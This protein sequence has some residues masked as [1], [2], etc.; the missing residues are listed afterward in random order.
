[1]GEEE[2]EEEEEKESE[3]AAAPNPEPTPMPSPG[4]TAQCVATLESYYKDAKVWEPYCKNVGGLGTCPAPMCRMTTS[5]LATTKKHNFLGNA[6]LQTITDVDH[7]TYQAA[8]E[9]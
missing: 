1:M 8:E 3:T 9:L 4:S 6:L 2:E 7:G 5:L